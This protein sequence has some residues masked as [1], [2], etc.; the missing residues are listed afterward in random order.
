MR[1]GVVMSAVALI[2]LL[3]RPVGAQDA[4]GSVVGLWLG[5]AR[6]QGGL[7]N[8]WEFHADGTV[9]FGFGAVVGALL[10]DTYRLEGTRLTLHLF[11]GKTTPAG[12]P[13]GGAQT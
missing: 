13:V 10:D 1:N 2:G 3:L 4:T 12:A 11:S 7:G 5:E 8:W 9:E 6:T